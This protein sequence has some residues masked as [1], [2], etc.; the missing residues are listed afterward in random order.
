MV[1]FLG[2]IIPKLSAKASCIL[3]KQND[4]KWT[5]IWPWAPAAKAQKDTEPYTCAD[6][7]WPNKKDQSVN[8]PETDLLFTMDHIS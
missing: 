2:K 6:I 3:H 5:A 1:N 7:L 4:F 8:F